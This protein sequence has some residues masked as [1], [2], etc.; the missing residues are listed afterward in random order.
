VSER[1]KI[2]AR[3]ATILRERKDEYAGLIT[4]EVGKLTAQSY[5]EVELSAAILEY[6]ASHAE[7]FLKPQVLAESPD[8]EVRT[9]PIGVLRMCTML[10]YAYVIHTDP[11]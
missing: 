10:R 7:A 5:G 2:V 8:C 3:A 4:L 6:Y 11:S 9:E 1:S